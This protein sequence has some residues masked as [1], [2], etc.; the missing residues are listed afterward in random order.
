MR[1]LVVVVAA[2]VLAVGCS[3][4]SG[5]PLKEI[6]RVRSGNMDVVLLSPD[7][8]LHQGKNAAVLEFRDSSGAL[9]DVGMV[10]VNATM[11]MAGMA[12]MM[13]GAEVRPTETKGRYD[14]ACDFNMAGTWRMGVDWDG[15]AGR[16]SAAMPGTVR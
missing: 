9:A 15:P 1:S 6:Q 5:S 12:P 7:E 2:V 3:R 10:R 14:V 11:P 16:G 4:G 8:G 13:A